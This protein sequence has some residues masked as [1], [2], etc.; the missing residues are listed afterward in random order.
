MSQTFQK[1]LKIGQFWPGFS[2]RVRFPDSSVRTVGRMKIPNPSPRMGMISR[3]F[4][5]IADPPDRN[6]TEELILGQ[7]DKQT[8]RQTN[9]HPY[10]I[11]IIRLGLRPSLHPLRGSI[12][13]GDPPSHVAYRPK[14]FYHLLGL[15]PSLDPLR[16]SP[17][18]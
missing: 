5:Y 16:G 3:P 4:W 7:T 17:V 6:P 13:F 8:N 14:H 11:N 9:R 12:T 15:R 10:L 18:P 2:N 1:P